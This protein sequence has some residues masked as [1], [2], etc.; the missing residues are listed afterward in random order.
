MTRFQTPVT[1]LWFK[2]IAIV[3]ALGIVLRVVVS[4]GLLSTMPQGEDG[5]SYSAQAVEML[6]GSLGYHYFPPGTALF[7][8]PFYVVFGQSTAVDHVLGVVLTSG[9]LLSGI[10]LASIILGWGKPTFVTAVILALYPHSWLS[11]TQL[12]SQPLTAILLAIAVG[13]AIQNA[14]HW[15]WSRWVGVTVCLAAAML[16]RPASLAILVVMGA[17]GFVLWRRRRISLSAIAGATALLIVGLSAAAYPFMEHNARVG[18]GWT[19]STNNEWNLFLGNTPYT[20]DYKT[21]HFGQRSFNQVSPEA[22]AYMAAILPHESPYAATKEQR[23]AMRSA[24]IDYITSHPFRTLYRVSNRLRG[25]WGMD[26]TASRVIQK[27]YGL[28]ELTLVVLLTM[29]GGGYFVVILLAL[30]APFLIPVGH[31]RPWKF[32]IG[33]IV[34]IMAPYLAAFALAKYHL[35]VIL[36]LLPISA[37]GCVV[38]LED[39]R[40]SWSI[41]R[42]SRLWWTV[43][44]VCIAIQIEHFTH[45]IL[46][47]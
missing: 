26:Y 38:L 22:R 2:R 9:F 47:R 33:C 15:S 23:S 29:E 25:F 18:Q 34:A 8:A 36:L 20:P 12:S 7:A 28:S 39:L 41:L 1:R 42:K 24:A 30:T 27:A 45:L 14:E 40:G 11:A 17:G 31:Q 5:P 21:G 35:P 6:N 4:F 44:M 19:I 13:L 16:T 3:A 10:W 46:L 32:L 37:L 43:V